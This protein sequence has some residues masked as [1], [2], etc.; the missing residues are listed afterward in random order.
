M[1]SCLICDY[2]VD[3][4]TQYP[5]HEEF[6]GPLNTAITKGHE[7]V[8]LF[9]LATAKIDVNVKSVHGLAPL[10]AAVQRGMLAVVKHLVL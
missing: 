9:L 2:K 1:L 10:E 8:A 7:E 5:G 3:A 4:N 6:E